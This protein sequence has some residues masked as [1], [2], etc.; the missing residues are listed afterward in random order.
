MECLLSV[1]S[2]GASGWW[3]F[4]AL[5]VRGSGSGDAPRPSARG[6]ERANAATVHV[7]RRRCRAGR[8][9]RRLWASVPVPPLPQTL[10][11]NTAVPRTLTDGKGDRG[12]R[13]MRAGEVARRWTPT[14]SRRER[15]H[16]S[17]ASAARVARA[18]AS[19]RVAPEPARADPAAMG[20]SAHRMRSLRAARGDVPTR[21]DAIRSRRAI[22]TCVAA[23]P[24]EIWDVA[25]ALGTYRRRLSACNKRD[26]E[27]R[28]R[29]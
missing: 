22:R 10:E 16:R 11:K 20:S 4:Q 9:N 14:V 19:R 23:S 5:A 1:G 2:V 12:V 18:I 7:A 21:C 29:G 17:S 26:G 25:R 6:F 13:R 3:I 27:A 8:P 28:C 15:A 24:G